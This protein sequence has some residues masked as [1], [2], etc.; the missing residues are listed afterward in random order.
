MY[1]NRA[2]YTARFTFCLILSCWAGIAS[3]QLFQLKVDGA[4]GYDQGTSTGFQGM[5]AVQVNSS[6]V[7]VS[8]SS[9][10]LNGTWKGQRLLRWQFNGSQEVLGTLGGTDPQGFTSTS[11]A[12]INASGQVAA[13]SRKYDINHVALGDFGAA[14]NSGSATAIELPYPSGSSFRIKSINDSGAIVG[15]MQNPSNAAYRWASSSS[16]PDTLVGLTGSIFVF[17]EWINNSGVTVGYSQKIV[18]GVDLG[19]LAVR[20]D[21]GSV[22]PVELGTI[23]TQSSQPDFVARKINEQNVAVGYVVSGNT[24]GFRALR[25]DAS[26]NATELLGLGPEVGQY[27]NNFA[28]DVNQSGTVVGVSSKFDSQGNDLGPR[29]VR[30]S[31]SSSVAEEL[32]LFGLSATGTSYGSANVI[33]NAGTAGGYGAKYSQTGSPLDDAVAMLWLPNGTAIDLNSLNIAPRA[34]EPGTWELDYVTS[35]ADNGWM[36]GSGKFTPTGSA[37]SYNRDWIARVGLGGTWVN[38]NPVGFWRHGLSWDSGTPALGVGDA[39]FARLGTHRVIVDESVETRRV[40]FERGEVILNI[41]EQQMYVQNG[42]HVHEG[43]RAAIHTRVDIGMLHGDV[44]NQGTLAPGNSVG[45]LGIDGDLQNTGTLEF[46][47]SGIS[48]AEYDQLYIADQ[49][50]AGGNLKV[51]LDGYSPNAGDQFA[52]ISWNGLQYQGMQFDFSSA[53]LSSGLVW[54]TS[55]FWS[56]GVLSVTAVPEPASVGVCGLIGLILMLQRTRRKT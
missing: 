18:N 10:Y 5:A 31:A 4:P 56:A 28:T 1:N 19:Y 27:H 55:N 29:P 50:T 44:F 20:W 15:Y 40:D 45:Y 30:W 39:R 37:T 2:T 48:S 13:V 52:L 7:A 22:T 3:A 12:K 14:W 42:V 43:A 23:T 47:I 41:G 8:E 34:N 36:A 32:T 46:E 9:Y 38:P 17:P 49:F 11:Q 16:N 51:L 24:D 33:N 53:S 26:G 54:D 25:W 21:A 35:I 6:G